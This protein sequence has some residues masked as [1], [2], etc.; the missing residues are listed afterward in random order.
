MK[1]ALL[2]TALLMF[3]MLSCKRDPVP[4]DAIQREKYV[5]ILVDVH[6]AESIYQNRVM[7]K[8]DTLK[9]N[10]LYLAVL[11]KHGVNEQD[12]LTTS[13]YYSR[14]QKEYDK[15]Y[16]EVLSK[17]SLLIEDQGDPNKKTQGN[18]NKIVLDEK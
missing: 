13:L 15:I 11:K 7:L 8:R 17:I 16:A 3:I 6:L 12:M 18:V 1:K 9:S 4:R 10:E 5:D 14:N 2:F